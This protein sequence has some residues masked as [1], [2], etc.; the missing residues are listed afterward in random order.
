MTAESILLQAI[1]YGMVLSPNDTELVK[2]PS[3]HNVSL[4]N[5]IVGF[6]LTIIIKTVTLVYRLKGARRVHSVRCSVAD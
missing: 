2:E 6:R 5:Y 4:N 3:L 1:K